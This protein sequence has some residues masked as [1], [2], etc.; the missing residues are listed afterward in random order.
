MKKAL[1]AA[2]ALVVVA[3]LAVP[4]I[5]HRID[6]AVEDLV[7]E[8]TELHPGAPVDA[9]VACVRDG[10]L[11]LRM[12]NRCVWALGRLGDGRAL[13]VLESHHHGGRCDHDRELCQRELGKAI[14]ACRAAD[15]ARHHG[16]PRH[17]H[18][19]H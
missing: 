18:R 1:L 19:G 2:G 14:R 7:A 17:G 4:A 6:V 15:G 8:A 12:R 16:H 5:S 3:V 13:P 11:D 10:S 9:L